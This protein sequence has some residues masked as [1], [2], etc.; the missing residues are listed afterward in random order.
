MTSEQKQFSALT[1]WFL[2]LVAVPAMAAF[3]AS[4]W[5]FHLA[6][7]SSA[8]HCS[9]GLVANYTHPLATMYAWFALSIGVLWL[10]IAT[11]LSVRRYRRNG[12]VLAG[13]QTRPATFIS[14]RQQFEVIEESTKTA[15]THGL[16]R[17]TIRLSQSTLTSLTPEELQAVFDHEHQHVRRFDPLLSLLVSVVTQ[18]YGW[19]PGVR[20]AAQ[21]WIALRELTADDAATRHYAY[22][23]GLAGALL[24]MGDIAIEGLPSFSPNILRVDRLLQ[25]RRTS[26]IHFWRKRYSVAVLAMVVGAVLGVKILTAAA[27]APTAQLVQQCHEI[28]FMCEASP[29][30]QSVIHLPSAMS[31]YVQR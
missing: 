23:R 27:S 10:T 18:V 16:F 4:A 8:W 24:K 9:C 21:S 13:H 12:V 25:P 7:A 5:F 26:T 31:F 20:T 30:P 19:M 17:P 14:R 15:L 29:I 11:V 28:T 6:S 2:A 3:A 1:L 22:R